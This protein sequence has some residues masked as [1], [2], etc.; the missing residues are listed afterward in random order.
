[1][2]LE[3][4]ALPF[5]LGMTMLPCDVHRCRII[6][7]YDAEKQATHFIHED[8]LGLTIEDWE[9]RKGP[10]VRF[11]RKDYSEYHVF[12]KLADWSLTIHDGNA[13]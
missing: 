1:M 9:Y 5:I 4:E 11:L 6:T 3:E 2:A 13:L 8:A 7:W 10:Y 12:K